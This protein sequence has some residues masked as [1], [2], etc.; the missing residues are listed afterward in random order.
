MHDGVGCTVGACV[1]HGLSMFC[2]LCFLLQVLGDQ[3][4]RR[5]A[6]GEAL[7]PTLTRALADVQ[8]R[9]IFRCQAFIKEEVGGG[10]GG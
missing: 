9:L 5:G 2:T 7:R 6:G 10:G 8:G 3:L 4:G 1:Q